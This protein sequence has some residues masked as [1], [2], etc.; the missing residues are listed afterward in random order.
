VIK[1][2]RN[3]TTWAVDHPT[4]PLPASEQDALHLAR[5]A[6]ALTV[7]PTDDGDEGTGAGTTGAAGTGPTSSTHQGPGG[8]GRALVRASQLLARLE[9]RIG[10]LQEH[11][12]AHGQGQRRR[13]LLAAVA[14]R[15]SEALAGLGLDLSFAWLDDVIASLIA[16]APYVD[17]ETVGPYAHHHFDHSGNVDVRASNLPPD[18]EVGLFLGA[19]LRDVLRPCPNVRFVALLDEF[20][21]L[22]DRPDI[23]A[24]QRDLYVIEMYHLLRDRGLLRSGDVPGRDYVLLRESEL[25]EQVDVLIERLDACGRGVIERTAGDVVFRPA[26]WFV[27]QLALHSS[28]RQRELSRQGILLR[29]DGRPTCHAMDAAGFLNPINQRIV[30]LLMLDSQYAAQQDKTYALV[31]ALDV[32]RQESYHNVFYDSSLL[33]PEA[34][35]LVTFELMAE[36]ARRYLREWE[37]ST[38]WERF[39]SREYVDRNYGRIL[40]ADEEIVTIVAGELARAWP[41]VGADLPGITAA[42]DVGAGPNLYP[43]MLIAPYVADG[44]RLTLL[45]YTEANRAY[46]NAVLQ[47]APSEEETTLWAA[48]ETLMAS[49][50][51]D[52][53]GGVVDRVRRTATVAAGSIFDLPADGYDIVSSFFVA[54][55]ITT[56]RREFRLAIRSLARCLRPR[57]VLVAAHMVGSY[58]YPAGA[59]THFP[60]V[61]LMLQDVDEAYRDADVEHTVHLVGHDGRDRPRDGYQGM[62]VVVGRHRLIAAGDPSAWTVDPVVAGTPPEPPGSSAAG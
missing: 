35:T 16:G 21:V 48:F 9:A 30:H 11:L 10:E 15:D 18:E 3:V 28:N 54:E 33:G 50:G 8:A 42:I 46:L 1:G 4:G 22:F 39:D 34:V 26:K 43:A 7:R 62:A 52:R 23:A 51:G 2:D 38:P 41:G 60:A 45:E 32:V 6:A 24:H 13:Q 58:G 19:A 29:R 56:S 47:G 31:R 40:P 12:D 57:G 49:V 61:N 53:Y 55:S 44:G 20:T 27:E 17:I 5:L 37:R 14:R 25:A 59:G 36:E